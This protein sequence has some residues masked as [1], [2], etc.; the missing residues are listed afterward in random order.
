MPSG[1]PHRLH[2][3]TT[4]ETWST[5]PRRNSLSD[6]VRTHVESDSARC[7]T[8]AKR[9]HLHAAR[10]AA[11]LRASFDAS[12]SIGRDD[13]VKPG[14]MARRASTRGDARKSLFQGTKCDLIRPKAGATC[15]LSRPRNPPRAVL[16]ILKS[17]ELP[18]R[19]RVR[20][21]REPEGCPAMSSHARDFDDE[22]E[23]DFEQWPDRSMQ[24][25]SVT[26]RPQP[27]EREPQRVS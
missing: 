3:H 26:A 10:T 15:A 1:L 11:R 18:A 6:I 9:V 7:A 12:A 25:R 17:R 21:T 22:P 23:H 20:F 16:L 5:R 4:I 19:Q 14:A 2:S 24:N 13:L 27:R 8:R